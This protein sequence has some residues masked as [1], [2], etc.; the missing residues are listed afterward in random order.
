MSHPAEPPGPSGLGGSASTACRNPVQRPR[1]RAG[2]QLPQIWQGCL[3]EEKEQE[4]TRAGRG[5]GGGV[6][7]SPALLE[8][9]QLQQIK[10]VPCTQSAQ[11]NS[12][13]H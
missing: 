13:E 3:F 10:I 1:A 5:G 9:W 2:E 11:R 6:R 4:K 8:Q 7:R 12:A